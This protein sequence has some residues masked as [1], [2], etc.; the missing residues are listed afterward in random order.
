METRARPAGSTAPG[1]AARP[2]LRELF[3]GFLF[4]ALSSFGGALPWA[5]RVIVERRRWLSG[6]QFV[7]LLS[8]CLLLP[9]PNIMNLSVALGARARGVRGSLAAVLG[10]SLVPFLL[11]V[12]IAEL[13]LRGGDLPLLRGALDGV[14][15]AAAGMLAATAAKMILPLLRRRPLT[16]APFIATTFLAVGLL[17][18]PLLPVVLL[19]APLS[20]AVVWRRR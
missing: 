3:T 18:W 2:G 19:L 20:F 17:R 15:A 7:D 12:G 14:G 9:G 5:R 10:F 8:L 1:L 4:L 13:Y 11:F 16:A 6:D